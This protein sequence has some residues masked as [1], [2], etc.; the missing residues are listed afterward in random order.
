MAFLREAASSNPGVYEVG[1]PA[2]ATVNIDDNDGLPVVR[3]AD[4]SDAEE[5]G[6]NP[7]AFFITRRGPTTAPLFVTYSYSYSGTARPA[8]DFV[9]DG[10]GY[11]QIDVEIPAGQTQARV[12]I[13]PW[14]DQL[15]EGTET[16]V[17]TLE[18]SRGVDDYAIG[19][20]A[21]ATVNIRDN[22]LPSSIAE[23]TVEPFSPDPQEGGLTAGQ[24]R[25]SRRPATPGAPPPTGE[26]VVRFRYGGSATP[27]LD[28]VNV[29]NGG[30]VFTEWPILGDSAVVSVFPVDDSVSEGTETVELILEPSPETYVIGTPGSASLNILDND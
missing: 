4:F 9:N 1:S 13:I 25:I 29:V 23:V 8:E 7:G 11:V 15:I 26:L 22:D 12:D 5:G 17:L 19:D 24:F 20:P 14:D 3:I 6:S 27:G 21:S 10:F 28:F 30:Q 16:V 18:P 2:S